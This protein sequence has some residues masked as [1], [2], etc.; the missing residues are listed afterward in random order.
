[1]RCR[2]TLLQPSLAPSPFSLTQEFLLIKI[3]AAI[4]P[5]WHLLLR[6]HILHLKI[7][8]ACIRQ[9][10]WT[11]PND[12]RLPTSVCLHESKEESTN[13]EN[14]KRVG[15]KKLSME[16][17]EIGKGKGGGGGRGH[18]EGGGDTCSAVP[19]FWQLTTKKTG[20]EVPEPQ[21]SH[22]SRKNS[23]RLSGLPVLLRNPN[24]KIAIWGWDRSSLRGLL[25]KKS[26]VTTMKTT[27]YHSQ[28]PKP[29]PFQLSF[30][31][32][33]KKGKYTAYMK[34]VR[35]AS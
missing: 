19:P 16:L 23:P 14:L 6:G 5:S 29:Q 21:P 2:M 3:L 12:G 18:G 27:G 32:K 10:L 30:C 33:E 35:C 22:T 25:A 1:M 7:P 9:S 8:A 15:F 26:F 20:I 17:W 34:Y 11:L 24:Y 4:I 28:Q 31:G 13:K